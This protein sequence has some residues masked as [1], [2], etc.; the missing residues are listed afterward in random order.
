MLDSGQN[1][2]NETHQTEMIRSA[3]DVEKVTTTVKTF[4][5]HFAMNI[6]HPLTCISSGKPVT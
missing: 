1:L 4:L 6:D 3:S 5:N 2:K